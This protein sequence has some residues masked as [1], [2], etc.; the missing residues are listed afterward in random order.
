MMFNSGQVMMWLNIPMKDS[1]ETS[2]SSAMDWKIIN[3]KDVLIQIAFNANKANVLTAN[4]LITFKMENASS[5]VIQL[6]IVKTVHY[7]K[8]EN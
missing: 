7:N 2:A 3:V 4:T 6:K 8:Q 1:S 5:A